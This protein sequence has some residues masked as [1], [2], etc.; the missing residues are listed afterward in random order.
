MG[1]RNH[2]KLNKFQKCKLK[3]TPISK[4]MKKKMYFEEQ[5]RRELNEINLML[6]KYEGLLK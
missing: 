4:Y 6:K 5:E 2:N 1:K 3:N